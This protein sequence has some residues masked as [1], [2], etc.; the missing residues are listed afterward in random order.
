MLALRIAARD[1]PAASITA[2]TSSIR[3]S[4]PGVPL[5][6]SDIPTPRW[7]NTITLANDARASTVRP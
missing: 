5:M 3:A 6:R 7:S 1:E 4:S 2:R